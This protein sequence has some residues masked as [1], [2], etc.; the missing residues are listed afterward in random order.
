MTD[1]TFD[2]DDVEIVGREPAY[3]GYFQIDRYRLR[4]RLFAGGWSETVT[5]EVF[6]RGHA[7]A[8]LPY[9]PVREEV[10][11]IE[12]FRPGALAAGETPWL[13]EIVAGIIETGEG[14]EEVARREAQEE[15]GLRIDRLAPIA[16]CF[17]TP[18]GSSETCRIY[19]GEC[20]TADVGG[21]HGVDGEHEDI[22]TIVV[23]ID[24]VRDLIADGR[25]RNAIA[26]I[27]LQWLT[28][29]RAELAAAWKPDAA[30]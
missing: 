1:T 19:C 21:I 16:H 28:M 5:R 25:V 29:H 26:L 4:H 15:A 9:D 23:G 17:L 27:A 10:V 13:I 24:A 14:P 2:A 30:P 11:L 3:R 6:E 12:Q 8:V 7:A 20:S 22:R 18:G